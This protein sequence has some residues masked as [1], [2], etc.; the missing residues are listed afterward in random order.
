MSSVV[1]RKF[2]KRIRALRGERKWSQEEF[3]HR[4]NMNVSFLSEI[5]TGKKEPCLTRIHRMARGFG[6]SMSEL[7]RGV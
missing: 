1:W 5:E 6:I 3:A 2:G 7:M 4:I